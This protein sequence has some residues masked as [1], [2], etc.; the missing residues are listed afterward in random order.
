[1]DVA[2]L[3]SKTEGFPNAV[4]EAMASARPVVS[5]AVGGVPELIDDGHTGRLVASRDPAAFADAVLELL[6]D[7]PCAAAIGQRAAEHV[8]TRFSVDAMVRAH[9][10]LYERLLSTARRG[11]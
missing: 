5:A 10:E 4:L 11:A 9:R 7:G 6:G 3:T 2:V 8:R 1:M